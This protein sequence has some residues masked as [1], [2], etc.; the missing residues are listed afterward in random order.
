[1][2]T[3][4]TEARQ[5]TIDVADDTDPSWGATGGGG[6]IVFTSKR[7]GSAQLYTINPDGSNLSA[8]QIRTNAAVQVVFDGTQFVLAKR[9]FNDRVVVIDAN[10]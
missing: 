2:N 4:G 5:L 8:G 6:R 3:N 7:S 10:P 9:P 1:M